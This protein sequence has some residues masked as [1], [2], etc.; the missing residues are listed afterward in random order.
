MWKGWHYSVFFF[1]SWEGTLALAKL[2]HWSKQN[3]QIL[4]FF[5]QEHTL[6][7][8]IFSKEEKQYS[9]YRTRSW[10][11]VLSI[12]YIHSIVQSIDPD[13]WWLHLLSP[14]SRWWRWR[15]RLTLRVQFWGCSR[16]PSRWE[17]VMEQ[18]CVSASGLLFFL[19]YGLFH[20]YFSLS[21][22]FHKTFPQIF[23]CKK[24]WFNFFSAIF[25]LLPLE[26][27]LFSWIHLVFWN[28]NDFSDVT[29]K[30]S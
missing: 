9:L 4:S 30:L 20:S 22:T 12:V 8:K 25:F 2:K 21:T 14:P 10:L 26:N 3:R 24:I 13:P 1:S 29:V 5:L 18:R 15:Y 23:S 6:S 28:F 7:S 27:S 19:R 16:Y 11:V 17:K